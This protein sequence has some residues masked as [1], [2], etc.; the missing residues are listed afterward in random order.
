MKKL[1]TWFDPYHQTFFFF[2]WSIIA[3]LLCITFCV[4]TAVYWQS[5]IV[6]VLLNN[7]IVYL[8]NFLMHEMVGHNLIGKVLFALTYNFSPG[9]ANWLI[10][11]MGNGGET[12]I[13]FLIILFWLRWK[14]GNWVLPPLF[15]WLATTLF[16]AGVYVSDARACSLPLA[17]ADMI[18][19]YK[20]GEICGDWHYVLEPL[21]WLEYD[22]LIGYIFFAAAGGLLFIAC[23]SVWYYWTHPEQYLREEPVQ[24]ILPPDLLPPNIGEDWT[25]DPND[26][27]RREMPS[28]ANPTQRPKMNVLNSPRSLYPNDQG[29]RNP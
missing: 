14:G 2:K 22:H 21:G 29:K 11:I 15:Y 5:G 10:T 8:P 1:I 4:L 23:Y 18:T 3:F 16:G 7:S 20:E 12:L 26:F 27:V 28:S 17:S 19:S 9:L 24:K 25:P 13:P 6:D